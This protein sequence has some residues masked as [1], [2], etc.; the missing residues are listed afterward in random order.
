MYKNPEEILQV[1][2]L[3]QLPRESLTPG[4]CWASGDRRC[5]NPPPSPAIRPWYVF[6]HSLGC[7]WPSSADLQGLEPREQV[8]GF[9]VSCGLRKGSLAPWAARPVIQS[10]WAWAPEGRTS[11]F[12]LGVGGRGRGACV[13]GII[14][15]LTGVI[16]RWQWV[17]PSRRNQVRKAEWSLTV[18]VT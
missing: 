6:Y 3:H 15:H 13:W 7:L 5:E 9:S 2:T 1:E 10:A 11:T 8:A 12:T 16:P 17:R 18:G 14:E 4:G